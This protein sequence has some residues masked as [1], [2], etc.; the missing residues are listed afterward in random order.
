MGVSQLGQ[1][2]VVPVAGTEAPVVTAAPTAWNSTKV[3]PALNSVPG[4]G[5]AGAVTEK[6]L[7]PPLGPCV[8]VGVSAAGVMTAKLGAPV[9]TRPAAV[10]ANTTP[11][12]AALERTAVFL[13]RIRDSPPGS[14]HGLA[15]NA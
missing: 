7:R 13:V 4:T 5:G 12:R 14:R 3:K 6:V 10:T 1:Q 11:I 8:T 15:C 2:P 9:L